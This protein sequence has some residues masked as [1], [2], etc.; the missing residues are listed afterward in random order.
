M[1]PGHARSASAHQKRK[2][3]F[4][5]D[6]LLFCI[7]GQGL[8]SHWPEIYIEVKKHTK[9]WKRV[10]RALLF[11]Q[12]LSHRCK[13]KPQFHFFFMHSCSHSTLFMVST[14]EEAL[15]DFSFHFS[16]G[17]EAHRHTSGAWSSAF[18]W[19]AILT[20]ALGAAPWSLNGCYYIVPI[21]PGWIWSIACFLTGICG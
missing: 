4:H 15:M 1:L 12:N 7:H 6:L 11:R 16:F 13:T 3:S 14:A 20:A 2:T 17:E 19:S 5:I 8:N 9:A 21:S 18:L 10:E